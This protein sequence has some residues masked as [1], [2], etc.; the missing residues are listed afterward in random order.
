MSVGSNNGPGNR[1]KPG[2]SGNPKGRP[3]K[4]ESYSD[5]LAQMAA[6]KD[7]RLGDG[8]LIDRKTALCE[9]MWT[10]ALRDKDTYAAKF[11]IE[12]LEGK[13]PL[14]L[15]GPDDDDGNPTPV[16]VIQTVERMSLDDW[17]KA[18]S[19]ENTSGVHSPD[20]PKPSP[21]PR[22]RSS[23]E[24]PREAG[25]ATS[26]SATTSRITKNGGKPG[27]GSSSGGRTRSSTKS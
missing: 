9:M 6:I 18:Y 25:K 26:S 14:T 23:S 16:A 11:I 5:I 19:N 1:F 21:A 12:R 13:T 24:E 27:K 15:Q 2:Q 22:R 17:R 10:K 7:I 3:K 8:T 4:G 20:K